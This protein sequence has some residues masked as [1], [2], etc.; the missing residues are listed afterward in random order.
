MQ[1][2]L[3]PL[4][5]P[6][7]DREEGGADPDVAQEELR[8]CIFVTPCPLSSHQLACVPGKERAHVGVM[9]MKELLAERVKD[10]AAASSSNA[11]EVFGLQ[12]VFIGARRRAPGILAP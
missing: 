12:K 5:S 7:P 2:L 11:V 4:A 6:K 3:A 10:S 9:Q 8:V 1:R